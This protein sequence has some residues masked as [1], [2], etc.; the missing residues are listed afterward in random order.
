MNVLSPKAL[1]QAGVARV[2]II[3]AAGGD[4]WMKWLKRLQ[5]EW[6]KNDGKPIEGWG[7]GPDLKERVLIA[8]SILVAVIM[9]GATLW[10]LLK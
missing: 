6:A 1:D 9:A 5:A 4:G 10:P 3:A 2:V 7:P 8:F